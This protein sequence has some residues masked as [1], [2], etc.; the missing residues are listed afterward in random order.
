VAHCIPPVFP[1]Y[2]K[3]F[4]SIN[5]DISVQNDEMTWQEEEKSEPPDSVRSVNPIEKIQEVV[6]GS[7]L[8]YDGAKP[9]SGLIRIHWEQ[10]RAVSVYSFPQ[11]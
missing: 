4:H 9:S 11:L 2:A 8:V 5:E 1:A 10:L 3:L 6:R 7:T